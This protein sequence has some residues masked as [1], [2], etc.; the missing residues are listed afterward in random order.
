M[1]DGADQAIENL[2]EICVAFEVFRFMFG[3]TAAAV[4]RLMRHR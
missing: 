3:F 1:V 4:R 2:F